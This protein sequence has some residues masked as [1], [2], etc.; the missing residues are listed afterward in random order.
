MFGSKV[1]EF[2]ERF[3]AL[4]ISFCSV[5]DQFLISP[6]GALRSLDGFRVFSKEI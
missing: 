1:L 5:V 3:T 6:S 4:R 2:G